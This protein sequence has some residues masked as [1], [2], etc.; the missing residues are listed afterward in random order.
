MG[1]VGDS[2][3][4]MDQ[5]CQRLVMFL[6]TIQSDDHKGVSQSDPLICQITL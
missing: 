1:I 4:G 3:C 5:T 6:E 2:R